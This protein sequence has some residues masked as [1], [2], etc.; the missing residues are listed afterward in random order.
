MGVRDFDVFL[1]E[2]IAKE[3]YQYSDY[4]QVQQSITFV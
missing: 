2:A 4:V 3:S 1:K